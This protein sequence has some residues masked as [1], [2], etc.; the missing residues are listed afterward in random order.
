MICKKLNCHVFKI[1]VDGV[2]VRNNKV[3]FKDKYRH[4]FSFF[5]AVSS[6]LYI[7]CRKF[8]FVVGKFFLLLHFCVVCHFI[9]FC[10]QENGFVPVKSCYLKVAFMA[11]MFKG[12]FFEV[13]LIF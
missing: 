8:I 1:N 2:T 12:D 11:L 13:M 7:H 10:L 5:F 3:I 6:T 4:K 9:V